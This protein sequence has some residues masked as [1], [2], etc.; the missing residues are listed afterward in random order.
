MTQLAAGHEDHTGFYAAALEGL[1]KL[2]PGT[3]S[4][5]AYAINQKGIGYGKGLVFTTPNKPAITANI[6]KQAMVPPRT[7]LSGN[8][9]DTG[10]KDL[11]CTSR[12]F[13]YQ[14][15]GSSEWI[16]GVSEGAFGTGAL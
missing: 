16:N 6:D 14:L 13:Q 12:R 10:G 5:M 8:I 4:V 15:K 3:Y 7:V 9:T 11:V 2:G 1:E